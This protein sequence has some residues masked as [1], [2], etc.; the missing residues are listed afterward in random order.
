VEDVVC[1]LRP[2]LCSNAS[3]KL[4][5]TDGFK[6]VSNLARTWNKKPGSKYGGPEKATM[7]AEAFS[8][9]AL[10]A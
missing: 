1:K 5:T 9:F 6:D 3:D 10:M 8:Y 7:T 4:T 2:F